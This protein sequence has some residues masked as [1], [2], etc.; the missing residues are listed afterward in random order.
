MGYKES[1]LRY[2]ETERRYSAHTVR[3]YGTDISHFISFLLSG[4]GEFDPALVTPGD[5]REWI[6]F[7][8]GEG[9]T[10]STIQRKVSAIR[11]F[12]RFLKREG[13]EMCDPFSRVVLPKKGKRL[14]KFIDEDP[15]MKLLDEPGYFEDS[16]SG[17]RDRFVI[18]MLYCT[19]MRRAELINL[20][21][22]DVDLSRD[23]IKVYGKRGKERYIPLARSFKQRFQG[24]LSARKEIENAPE[25]LF[26][27]NKGNKLYD[28]FVYNIVVR[29]L[30]MVTT[31][32][33]RSPHMLRHSFAT[34]MLNRGAE[35]NSVKELLG[36]ATLSATEIYTH[37]SFEKMKEVY[38]KAHPRA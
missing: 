35:L 30:S 3:S 18:E 26:L 31:A 17:L 24:Y 34:H 2:L 9:M 15:L 1:F 20:R 19:G 13:V 36:H 23:L 4:S 5:I 16:Y 21:I 37:N 10:A 29:Y 33:K 25:W 12:Y 6:V 28:R 11:V 38:K 32:D 8:V 22:D 14:P 7:M 27:T